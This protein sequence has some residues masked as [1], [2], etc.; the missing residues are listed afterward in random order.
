MRL[1][2]HGSKDRILTISDTTGPIHTAGFRSLGTRRAGR[3]TADRKPSRSGGR[4]AVNGADHQ[5]QFLR[6][7]VE[8]NASIAG[9]VL[10]IG[11]HLWAIHG[12]IP[13]DCDVLMAAFDNYDTAAITLEKVSPRSLRRDDF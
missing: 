13:V 1:G 2:C 8:E 5:L 4:S 11:E 7:L 3:D 9:D 12:F 10:Q 6:D